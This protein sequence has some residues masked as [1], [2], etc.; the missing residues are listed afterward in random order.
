MTTGPLKPSDA[1]SGVWWGLG[2]AFL[3]ALGAGLCCA[4]PLVYLLFGVSLAGLSRLSALSWL[5]WPLGA[6]A[7]IILSWVFG[8]LYLSKRPLCAG[9][10]NRHL[11]WFFWAT[12]LVV[13]ALLTYPYFL[14]WWL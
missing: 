11:Q 12:V 14:A 1:R 8:R 3:S 5:Q 4:A 9:G 6:V 7:L 13:L 2:V 10:V